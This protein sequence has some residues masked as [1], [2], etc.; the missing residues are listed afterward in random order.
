[1]NQN[2]IINGE[3]FLFSVIS[4]IFLTFTFVLPKPNNQLKAKTMFYLRLYI[5]FGYFAHLFFGSR[6]LLED[7]MNLSIWG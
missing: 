5:L 1:M 6:L 7:V 2:L 4:V 3:T